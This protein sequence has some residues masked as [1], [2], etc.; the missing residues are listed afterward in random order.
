MD[1]LEIA[2]QTVEFAKQA[3]A[4]ESEVVVRSGT[5]LAVKVRHGEVEILK[6]S[7]SCGLG[8]RVFVNKRAAITYTSDLSEAALRSLTQETVSL[9]SLSEPDPFFSLPEGPFA[10]LSQVPQLDLYDPKVLEVTP[11]QRLLWA[12]EAEE[13]AKKADPR[14]TNSEGATCD[15][16]EG[17]SAFANSAGFAASNKGT[18]QSISVSVI[19]DDAEGKKRNGSDFTAARHLGD[20]KTPQAIG[21]RAAERA[22]QKLGAKKASTCEVPV[23]VD[24]RM[25]R[26]LIGMVAGISSGSSIYRK[27]SY[28]VGRENT[29]IASSLVTILDDPFLIRGH[30][31]RAYDG[32]GLATRRNTLVEEGI[33][34]TYLC[35]TY[36]ARKLNR[37]STGS[38]SRSIGGPPGPSTSN[39]YLVPG[40]T[41]PAD[42]I[43]EVKQGL[44]LTEMM[45][46]GFN[47]VTGDFSRGAGGFWIEDGKLSYPVSEITISANF[48]DLLQRIDAVGDDLEWISSVACPTFRISKMT[49]AGK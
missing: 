26:A 29:R 2:K 11:E 6:E 18:Y 30:G 36:S 42:M 21:A 46:F 31:S 20:L 25:G 7:R 49:I 35:D 40:T 13:A 10:D 39:L 22:T 24:P 3:G 19:A 27:S 8:I 12:R 33:L 43:R 17:F 5:D 48:D 37:Q 4:D 14:I 45:G 47:A 34:K 1:L 16:Y 9:A 15:S 44:Y 32:E 28:L 38:A 41:K 23:V